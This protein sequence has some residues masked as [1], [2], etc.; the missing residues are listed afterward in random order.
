MKKIEYHDADYEI[1]ESDLIKIKKKYWDVFAYTDDD[2]IEYFYRPVTKK[3]YYDGIVIC[4]KSDGRFDEIEFEDLLVDTAVIAPTNFEVGTAKA[5]IITALAN[6]IIL[7][8]GFEQSPDELSSQINAYKS[9]MLEPINQMMCYIKEAFPD[10][11]MEELD[12]MPLAKIIWYFSRADFILRVIK[13]IPIQILT[14]KEYMELNPLGDEFD[15]MLES[16]EKE[17]EE[18]EEK[19]EDNISKE[20]NKQKVTKFE[21]DVSGGNYSDFAELREIDA[22][23]RGELFND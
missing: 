2:G 4:T 23:M 10:V 16:F 3:E 20:T 14:P 17:N 7:K 19:E 8:S 12:D 6:E 15:K 5:G 1:E 11:T 18:T 13:N 21:T 9:E 22:F